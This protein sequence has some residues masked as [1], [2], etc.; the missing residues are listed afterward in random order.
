MHILALEWV[1]MDETVST[2][3]SSV[4]ALL[5]KPRIARVGKVREAQ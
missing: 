1:K 4:G 3:Y 2:N 5:D